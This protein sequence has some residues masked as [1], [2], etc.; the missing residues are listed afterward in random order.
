MAERPHNFLREG[1][2]TVAGLGLVLVVMIAWRMG[3][4]ATLAPH[5]TWARYFHDAGVTRPVTS[6]A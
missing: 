6:E 4:L 2:I 5:V 1:V 3:Q